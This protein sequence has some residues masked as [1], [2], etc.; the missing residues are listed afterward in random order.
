MVLNVNNAIRE[1]SELPLTEGCPSH[2][3]IV[4]ERPDTRNGV[5]RSGPVSSRCDR[6][7][8]MSSEMAEGEVSTRA[9]LV[10]LL[11]RQRRLQL[12]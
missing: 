10:F 7:G 2:R 1:A 4:R 11:L 8:T 9:K 5:F 12:S 3:D 6:W